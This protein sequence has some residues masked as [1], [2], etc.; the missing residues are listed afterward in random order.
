MQLIMQI[1]QYQYILAR[2]MPLGRSYSTCYR[3]NMLIQIPPAPIH[4]E[5]YLK[6]QS[7]FPVF[8]LCSD[9]TFTTEVN[10][11]LYV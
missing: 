3:E 4:L 9:S 8:V 6:K 10:L 2:Y 5:E 1:T 11:L 7:C